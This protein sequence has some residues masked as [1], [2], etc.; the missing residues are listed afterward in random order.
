MVDLN[1][2][3]EKEG[4]FIV[5]TRKLAVWRVPASKS[6]RKSAMPELSSDRSTPRP[7]GRFNR[8]NDW[9]AHMAGIE[10]ILKGNQYHVSA[11]TDCGPGSLPIV[12]VVGPQLPVWPSILLGNL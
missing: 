12:P 7:E 2:L 10:T 3:K 5:Q 8:R 11:G 6:D 9:L 4:L 1:L